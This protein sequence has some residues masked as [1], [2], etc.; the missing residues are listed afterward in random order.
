MRIGFIIL[1][2]MFLMTEMARATGNFAFIDGTYDMQI[3]IGEEVF[4][5]VVELKT[6]P[7]NIQRA[8]LSG[9]LTVPGVF[10]SPLDG[11]AHYAFWAALF[12]FRFSITAD[13]NGQKF[14]V[15]YRGQFESDNTTRMTG[16]AFLDGDKLLGHFTAVKRP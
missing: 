10:T 1:L 9:A 2:F 5:D 8:A 14:K 7:L 16:T 11:E 3:T 15:H 6:E 4:N 12:T 13:E